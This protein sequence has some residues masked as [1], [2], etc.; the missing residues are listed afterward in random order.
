MNK[1]IAVMTLIFALTFGSSAVAF[2]QTASTTPTVDSAT[3]IQQL[4]AQVA[5]LQAQLSELTK[6]NTSL[7]QTVQTLQLNSQLHQG[8]NGEEVRKLQEVLAT[9]PNLYSKDSITGFY[10]PLTAK[11]VADFQT[12]FGLESVGN[13]GPHTLEKINE[14]L[15]AHDA[16]SVDSLTEND[17]GDLGENQDMMGQS[18]EHGGA[19]SSATSTGTESNSSSHHG[20]DN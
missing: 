7:Q 4:Q 12:H 9:D 20:S 17:L 3:L 1:S 11:A 6:T 15:K 5:Q 8:M 13:V 2:A 18:G 16:I 14:L 10:G 19:M